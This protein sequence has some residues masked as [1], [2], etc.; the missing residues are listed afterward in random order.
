L[1]NQVGDGD[2]KRLRQRVQKQLAKV[3]SHPL[4]VS[5][6]QSPE[7][8]SPSVGE[9]ADFLR[10]RVDAPRVIWERRFADQERTLPS[11]DQ[12]MRDFMVK[13]R[14][15]YLAEYENPLPQTRP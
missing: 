10:C 1:E 9:V 4:F 6:L 7:S 2:I 5:F 8:F 11:T 14:E 15:A 3:R 13:C 12:A